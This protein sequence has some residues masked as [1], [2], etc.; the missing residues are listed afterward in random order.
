MLSKVTVVAIGL[1]AVL[2]LAALGPGLTRVALQVGHDDQVHYVGHLV[3][4]RIFSLCPCTANIAE[5]QY[6]RGMYHARTPRE[7]ALLTT[8][9]PTTWRERFDE[10]PEFVSA[11]VRRV[12]G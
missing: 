1:V 7:K 11:L 4:G 10:A 12:A 2:G 8:A 6:F 5:H 9:R 3:A